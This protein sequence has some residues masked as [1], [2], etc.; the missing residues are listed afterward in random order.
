LFVS[1]GALSVRS[2]T[3]SGGG[4]VIE[5]EATVTL[6]P[7]FKQ[8]S[9]EAQRVGFYVTPK[10]FN[11]YW[12]VTDNELWMTVSAGVDSD[13]IGQGYGLVE[14]DVTS[15][16]GDF[17]SGTISV[18]GTTFTI[19]QGKPLRINGLTT[20]QT[21]T[22]TNYG[23]YELVANVTATT[24]EVWGARCVSRSLGA[25]P[26]VSL[27]G[28]PFSASV[29]GSGDGLVRAWVSQYTA[30]NTT[31]VG[32]SYRIYPTVTVFEIGTIKITIN[33]TYSN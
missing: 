16:D 10:T 31:D 12:T 30:Q 17:R 2:G 6:S 33:Q 26:S 32:P 29:T 19:I 22:T 4:P 15:N 28:G 24:G 23:P 14:A 20:P 1:G 3:T 27:N 5:P 7:T 25:F 11:D 21:I 9:A 18:G 8:I 13:N